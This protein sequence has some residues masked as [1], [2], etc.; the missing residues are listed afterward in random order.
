M[1]EAFKHRWVDVYE[2]EG[3]RSGGYMASVYGVHPYILMNYKEDV[4]GDVFTLAYEGGHSM[5]SLYSAR[6]NPF[7]HYGYTIFEAEVA[8]TFNEQLLATYLLDRATD[9]AM[10]AH[11]IGKQVD[12][13]IGT[14]FRQTMFAEF[15]LQVHE[16]A[17]AQS[18]L[19]L[20]AITGTYRRLLQA[21][22]GDRLVL[23]DALSLECLRIPHFYS[24]FYVYKYATGISAAIALADRVMRGEEGACDDYLRFL[25]LGGSQFP[26]DE[27]LAAGVDMRSPAPVAQAIAHFGRLVDELKAVFSTL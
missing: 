5:H 21:H 3:K 22:F 6:N 14:L 12:S 8:S 4:L 9:N 1:R 7:S 15:E 24:A 19:T 11:L 27:L 17:E 26:L 18:P 23:D 16:M 13:I 25:T 10:R 20:D 2:T